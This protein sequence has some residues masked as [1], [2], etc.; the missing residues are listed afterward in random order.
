[1]NT[2]VG[3]IF[4]IV[5]CCDKSDIVA[6]LAIV[7]IRHSCNSYTSYRCWLGGLHSGKIFVFV[8]CFW[9]WVCGCV[10]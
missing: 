2:A 1:M 6:I 3:K 5:A 7:G 8:Q 9:N 10:V 4:T